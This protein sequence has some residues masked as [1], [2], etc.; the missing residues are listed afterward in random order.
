MSTE[1]GQAQV[2]NKEDE[3]PGPHSPRLAVNRGDKLGLP[4]VS[5]FAPEAERH[6]RDEHDAGQPE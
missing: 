2:V 3:L 4:E 6:M 1:S 5:Q